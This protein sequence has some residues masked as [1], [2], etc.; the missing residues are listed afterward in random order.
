MSLKKRHSKIKVPKG[1][2]FVCFVYATEEPFLFQ[3]TC[4][5]HFNDLNNFLSFHYKDID[6]I[7]TIF[8][9]F[10]KLFYSSFNIINLNTLNI[11]LKQGRKC[12][13][14]WI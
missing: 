3:W 6:I 2:F 4:E 12:K 11:C 10:G 1:V 8:L 14:D 5:E 9:T 13:N 7:D